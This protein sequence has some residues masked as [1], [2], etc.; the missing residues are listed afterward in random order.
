MLKKGAMFGLDARIALA[1]FGALSVIS[2]AALYSAIENA[3]VVQRVTSLSEA[4]KALESYLLDVGTLPPLHSTEGTVI[5]ITKLISSSEIGWKG[6][7]LPYE[8]GDRWG[9]TDIALE[10]PEYNTTVGSGMA[11]RMIQTT[12]GAF[13]LCTSG[14]NCTVWVSLL[15]Q[16]RALA[17]KIDEYVDGTVDK[18]SGNIRLSATTNYD[19]IWFNTGIRVDQF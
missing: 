16:D 11:L 17:K 13:T 18:D 9:H 4:A 7:Y 6:P 5:D 19:N 8:A 1:I 3:K 14:E 10:T 12:A 15:E 2:G